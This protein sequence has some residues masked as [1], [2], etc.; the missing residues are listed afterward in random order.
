MG[1]Q[2][3]LCAHA[4]GRQRGFRAGMTAT[5]DDDVKFCG[6]KHGG[7][8]TQSCARTYQRNVWAEL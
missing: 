5:D 2:Q 3:C 7:F 6:K 1:Q 4:G 8:R